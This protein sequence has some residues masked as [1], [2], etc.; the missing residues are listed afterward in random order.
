MN[1]NT[2]ENVVILIYFIIVNSLM[3][4][5]VSYVRRLYIPFILS[6]VELL[7]VFLIGIQMFYC[8]G[9][10]FKIFLCI[11]CIMIILISIRKNKVEKDWNVKFEVYALA[12]TVVNLLF[13]FFGLYLIVINGDVFISYFISFVGFI[14]LC[15]LTKSKLVK[16]SR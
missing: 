12:I 16:G 13:M 8:Q 10:Y 5:V 6:N 2:I 3:L 7:I 9:D 1:I 14:V 4:A 15:V 11:F